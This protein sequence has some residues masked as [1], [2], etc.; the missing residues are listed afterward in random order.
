MKNRINYS[1]KYKD[2]RENYHM[3]EQKP[4]EDEIIIDQTSVVEDELIID[5][6][7]TG[8]VKVFKLNVRLDKSTDYE[9]VTTLK[10]NEEILITSGLDDDSDWYGISTNDGFDGFVLKEYIAV[11]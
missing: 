1:N 8:K 6:T 10:E 5:E 7:K 4:I 11:D 9:P 3:K 2:K